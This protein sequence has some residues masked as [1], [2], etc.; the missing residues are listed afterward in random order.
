MP[1]NKQ[2]ELSEE[3][4]FSRW[5]CF[6]EKTDLTAWQAKLIWD[7]FAKSILEAK[8]LGADE[9]SRAY[10]KGFYEGLTASD[11]PVKNCITFN[12]KIRSDGD[13]RNKKISVPLALNEYL[14]GNKLYKVTISTLRTLKD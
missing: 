13:G 8:K 14:E 11:K 2:E 5:V 12:R 1:I 7:Y 6:N 3:Q 4:K 10:H 9:A